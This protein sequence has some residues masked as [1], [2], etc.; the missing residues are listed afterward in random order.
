MATETHTKYTFQEFEEDIMSIATWV[1]NKEASG[2]ITFKGVHG[3]PQGGVIPAVFLAAE[4]GLPFVPELDP[5]HPDFLQILVIDDVMDSGA[6]KLKY[7]LHSLFVCLHVK[8]GCD[9][10]A[11]Y[12]PHEVWKGGWV[13]YWWE[14][15]G[16]GGNIMSPLTRPLQYIEGTASRE[17]LKDTPKR[18]IESWKTLYGGYEQDPADVM[19][20]F[21]EGYDQMVVLGPI[22]M[23]SMCEHHM[24]PFFGQCYIAY[25]PNGKVIGISKLARLMEIFSRR[26]QIQERI[27]DQITDAL[28][29][30]LEPKG[31]ACL[32]QAKHFC[33]VARG[34]GKQNAVMT[35]NSL[36]GCFL[37]EPACR[38]EFMSIVNRSA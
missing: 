34:V 5:N 2:G 9:F 10:S 19:T 29:E 6:T 26:L 1:K 15:S 33:M 24:L 37:E 25:I 18:V 32:I 3:V 17:G 4:L 36:R 31:A 20:V 27:G 21:E 30:H 12:S 14:K 22:E 7:E 11:D 16:S 28:M 35:T 13:D 8:E 23:Y 38:E